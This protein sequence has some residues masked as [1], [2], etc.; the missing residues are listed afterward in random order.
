MFKYLDNK[1]IF[2]SSSVINALPQSLCHFKARNLSPSRKTDAFC[3]VENIEI[4]F[5][6]LG[7]LTF[8]RVL[9]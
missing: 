6:F 2:A 1:Y 3:K 8:F 9:L 4:F 5:K 7:L